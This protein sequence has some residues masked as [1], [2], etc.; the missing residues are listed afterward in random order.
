MVNPDKFLEKMER[1]HFRGKR[2]AERAIGNTEHIKE[3]KFGA[4]WFFIG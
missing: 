3:I 1:T 4:W 2:K